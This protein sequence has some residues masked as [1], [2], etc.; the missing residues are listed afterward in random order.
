MKYSLASM[1]GL[2]AIAAAAP[3]AAH[4]SAH[5]DGFVAHMLHWMSSPL[6]GGLTLIGATALG[7]VI[8]KILRKKA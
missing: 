8:V 7:I 6:H 2:T 5:S 1:A 4:G 3:A